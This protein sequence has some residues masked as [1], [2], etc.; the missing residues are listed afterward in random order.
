MIKAKRRGGIQK[1]HTKQLSKVGLTTGSAGVNC[2]KA[3]I[4]D[5]RPKKKKN[6]NLSPRA[7]KYLE[8]IKA[9]KRG[10]IEKPPAKQLSK[11]GLTTQQRAEMVEASKRR[12]GKCV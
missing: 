9:Q 5:V 3:G 1:T 4:N 7:Q 12:M 2:D 6:Q 11:A 8:K 10:E